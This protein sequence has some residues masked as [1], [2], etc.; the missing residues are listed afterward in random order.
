MVKLSGA[1]TQEHTRMLAELASLKIL[2]SRQKEAEVKTKV[3]LKGFQT[4][5]AKLDKLVEAKKAKKVFEGHTKT[6]IFQSPKKGVS[7]RIRESIPD[8][9]V[10]PTEYKWTIKFDSE[11]GVP[12]RPLKN[13]D[14]IEGVEASFEAAHR[15]L[16]LILHALNLDSDLTREQ[17]LVG[18]PRTSYV[19]ERSKAEKKKRAYRDLQV[20]L[21]IFTNVQGRDINPLYVVE[22]EDVSD[23]SESIKM[24]RITTLKKSLG[25]TINPE[26]AALSMK[27]LLIKEGVL[28]EVYEVLP[29]A[30]K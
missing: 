1:E 5:R 17:L 16:G 23:L 6:Y 4:V 12:T 8:D 27:A 29:R 11:A 14:E 22:A 18:K 28:Q 19:V 10:L 13:K 25:L 26:Y 24:D 7:V 30:E 20:D 21:D 15:T 9:S 3:T 2:I